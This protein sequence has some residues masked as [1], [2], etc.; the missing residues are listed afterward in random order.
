M[1]ELKDK[2]DQ[3][4]NTAR[5]EGNKMAD[6]AK[7]AVQNVAG[8]VK[9]TFQD[10]AGNAANMAN[11]A[12][13]Q[14]RDTAKEWYGAAEEAATST[15]QQARRMAGDAVD[16]ASDVGDELTRVIQRNPIP[17]VLAAVGI[18]FLAAIALRRGSS[19]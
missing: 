17:C 7:D 13:S 10:V 18:G 19:S 14:V 2:M 11:K 3:L 1:P 5:N 8:A 15:A 4:G 16:R 9:D 12:A 6:K